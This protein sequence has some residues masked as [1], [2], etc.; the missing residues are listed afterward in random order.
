MGQL[1]FQT[2]ASTLVGSM[3]LG[4]SLKLCKPLFSH[5]SKGKLK[6]EISLGS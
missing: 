3:T 2:P 5:L 6:A 1:G 4:R